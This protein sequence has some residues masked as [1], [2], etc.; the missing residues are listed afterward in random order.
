MTM[1]CLTAQKY[2]L[3]NC[4]FQ[5]RR[6]LVLVRRKLINNCMNDILSENYTLK[7]TNCLY[8]E[9]DDKRIWW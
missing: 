2:K 7:I 3:K 9:K 6:S 5:V 8:L 4:P 1:N